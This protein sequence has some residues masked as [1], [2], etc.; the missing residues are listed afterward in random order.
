MILDR[1]KP[2]R[3]G[4]LRRDTAIVG[5]YLMSRYVYVRVLDH[6]LL[7]KGRK[8]IREHRLVMMEK[9][10]RKI[11]RSIDVH[12]KRKWLRLY[13]HPDNLICTPH[14]KHASEHSLNRSKEHKEKLRLSRVGRKQSLETIEKR[15]NGL[16][17]VPRTEE[18]KRK[19]S[20]TKLKNSR[21]WHDGDPSSS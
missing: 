3:L 21:H 4:W 14:K 16:R 6:Y 20:I 9:L 10:N 15:I 17:G 13:N 7:G 5:R 1:K 19:I 8:L 2:I 11:P 18:V 12:H